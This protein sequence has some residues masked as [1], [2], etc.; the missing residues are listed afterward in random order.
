MRTVVC[1]GE[2]WATGWA[3]FVAVGFGWEGVE[4]PALFACA[5]ETEHWQKIPRERRADKQVADF[6][7]YASQGNF[8]TWGH[9]R[10]PMKLNLDMAR[11][12]DRTL[13]LV[14]TFW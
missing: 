8:E 10:F 14:T 11:L 4:P 2:G 5:Q 1:C 3:A 12:S 9:S 6:T 7:A 13:R